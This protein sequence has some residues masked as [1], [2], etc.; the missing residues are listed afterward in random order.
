MS[1]IR[2]LV[3]GLA[4]CSRPSRRLH[5]TAVRIHDLIRNHPESAARQAVR[6]AG[7][8]VVATRL[9]GEFC[10]YRRVFRGR[11]QGIDSLSVT[12]LLFCKKF[13]AGISF[14]FLVVA[15]GRGRKDKLH[16]SSAPPRAHL[17]ACHP[18]CV[19]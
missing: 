1:L 14:C 4:V 12:S 13:L 9:S 8:T 17:H 2:R 19:R 15:E 16:G 18:P 3:P 10:V 11:I 6:T 7:V 5:R